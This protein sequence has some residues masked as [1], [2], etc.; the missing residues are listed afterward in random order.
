ML[1]KFDPK[2]KYHQELKKG[3]E[4]NG[5]LQDTP[6]YSVSI[7]CFKKAGFELL[8][9]QD[10]AAIDEQ[11]PIPWYDC[12][13]GKFSISGFRYTRVGR[14]LTEMM[15][16]VLEKLKIAPQGAR[17]TAHMLNECARCCVEAGK[18]GIFTPNFFIL[19][20]KPE[21]KK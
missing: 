2:N 1:D 7:D 3:I 8:E 18:L 20:R 5:G 12:L 10:L 15:V 9:A 14:W 21:K 4:V 11:N 16:G 13:D 19:G 6:H 17:D